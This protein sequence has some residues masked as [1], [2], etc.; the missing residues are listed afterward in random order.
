[1]GEDP[2]SLGV[3]TLESDLTSSMDVQ[4]G[5]AGQALNHQPLTARIPNQ[6]NGHH[7]IRLTSTSEEATLV[8]GKTQQSLDASRRS[9]QVTALLDL[10][11]PIENSAIFCPILKLGSLN[12]SSGSF[13]ILSTVWTGAGGRETQWHVSC[14]TPTLVAD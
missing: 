9:R 8:P 11:L 1:M 6:F 7:C 5:N 13:L 10:W 12:I 4:S 2:P 3:P 14:P